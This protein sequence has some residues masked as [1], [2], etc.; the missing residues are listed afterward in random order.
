MRIAITSVNCVWG[1]VTLGPH[2]GKSLC[3]RVTFTRTGFDSLVIFNKHGFC[4]WACAVQF[5]F[6]ERFALFCCLELKNV[7]IIQWL[8][9]QK[10]VY[11][12]FTRLR[13]NK[14]MFSSVC[15]YVSSVGTPYSLNGLSCFHVTGVNRFV[16]VVVGTLGTSKLKKKTEEFIKMTDIFF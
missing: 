5:I 2:Q 15:I 11:R 8:D 4:M 12:I 9:R 3:V 10:I 7:Y 1:V 6:G 13:K 14:I 16:L